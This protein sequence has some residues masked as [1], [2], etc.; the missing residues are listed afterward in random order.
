MLGQKSSNRSGGSSSNFS[1]SCANESNATN[2]KNDE[3]GAGAAESTA[4]FDEY[5]DDSEPTALRVASGADGV[6]GKNQK[7][8][9]RS[10]IESSTNRMGST[11]SSAWLAPVSLE[12]D[13]PVLFDQD[14]VTALVGQLRST[15]VPAAAAADIHEQSAPTVAE[16]LAPGGGQNATGNSDRDQ[17]S[18]T[19]PGAT[20]AGTSDSNSTAAAAESFE[21]AAAPKWVFG[22][23]NR[24]GA[25]V[26]PRPKRH[27][28]NTSAAPDCECCA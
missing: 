6:L 4:A 17:S 14:A 23:L 9:S 21:G 1:A 2:G 15:D 20:A 5:E 22:D 18:S 10:S 24:P 25:F 8:A 7:A 12:L 11:G 19:R 28:N 26:R 16:I 3:A 13:E 27:P